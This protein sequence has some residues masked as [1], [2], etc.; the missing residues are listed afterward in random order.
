M[1]KNWHHCP[2]NNPINHSLSQQRL[3]RGLL[4]IVPIASWFWSHTHPCLWLLWPV[5][6][7]SPYSNSHNRIFI[8]VSPCT[9][10]SII[11]N[12][13]FF[14]FSVP[15]VGVRTSEECNTG[16]LARHLQRGMLILEALARLGAPGRGYQGLR[17]LE[18]WPWSCDLSGHMEIL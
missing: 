14:I 3:K 15:M 7:L 11:A 1:V 5:P 9:K 12:N 2:P 16:T 18:S 4:L 13:I 6:C 17:E 10:L 8:E